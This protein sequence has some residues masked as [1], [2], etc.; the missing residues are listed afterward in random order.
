MT[1]LNFN[2][3]TT[4][5]YILILTAIVAH[6]IAGHAIADTDRTDDVPKIVVSLAGFELSTPQGA[7][8][9]YGRIRSAA[10]IV[11]RVDQSRELAQVARASACFRRAVGDA[12]AQ[13]NRPL[14]SELHARRTGDPI[15]MVR[16]ARR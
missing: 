14:L 1:T 15:E 16:S 2:V 4:R 9:V 3:A 12:V 8:M 11:C 7:N 5:R 6:L 10:K 13:A